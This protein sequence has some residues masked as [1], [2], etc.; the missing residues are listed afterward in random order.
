LKKHLALCSANK[1]LGE[2][3]LTDVLTGLSNRRYAMQILEKLWEETIANSNPLSCIM[4][5][6]DSFKQV[7]DSYGHDAGDIVLCKLAIELSDNVRTDDIV[8]RLGGDEFLIICPNTN[9]EGALNLA[10]NIHNKIRKLNVAVSGGSWHGSIS[11]GVAVKT[12]S[13]KNIEGLLKA[14]DL[15]VYA[16]KEAGRDCVRV[17]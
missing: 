1:K 6:A 4:I 7:N 11:V 12:A 8:C 13:M 5:D 15:G 16:A 2:F 3:A 17:V 10:N 14:A 9:K